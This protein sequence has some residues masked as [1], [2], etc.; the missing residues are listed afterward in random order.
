MPSPKQAVDRSADRPESDSRVSRRMFLRAGGAGAL[1][2]VVAGTVLF[3]EST[4]YAQQKWDH[5]AD[6]VVAGSGGG[7]CTA[8]VFA[9][10]AKAS[11]ILLEKGV[12]FGGT[13]AKS[14]GIFWI[15]NH[16]LLK[17]RG[18]VDTKEDFLR[19]AARTGYPTVYNPA[20]NARLGIPDDMYQLLSTFYDHGASTIDALVALGLKCHIWP[21]LSGNG[22]DMPDYYAQLPE[23]KVPRGRG[24][25]PDKVDGIASGASLIKQLRAMIDQRKIPVLMEH[26]VARLVLNGKGEVVGVEAA[27]EGKIVTIRAHKGVIFG[28]GGFTANAEMCFNYLRG[29]IFGGCGVQTNE[30]DLVKIASAVRAKL[31]NMNH[32]WWSSVLV[33]QALQ[34]RATPGNTSLPG[35]S[36]VSV[37]CYGKRVVNE[38]LQYNERTQA[39]FY[40]DPVTGRYPNQILM[41]IYDQSSRER[42][43]GTSGAVVRP[44]LN[45]PYVISGNTLE[46]LT[47]AIDARLAKI[48]DK[49]GNYRLDLSFLPNL[50]ETIARFNQF[51]E[52]G[53]D[54]DFHR[55]EAPVEFA[56]HGQ[57]R[58]NT[59][60]NITMKP[61]ANTGPYYAVLMGGGT[62]DTKG[63]PKIS[64]KGEI[65]DVDEKPIPGLY[66]CGN[67]IASPA[68]QAYWAG[69]GT[70]GPGMVFGALAAKAAASST[71]KQPEASRPVARSA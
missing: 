13:T 50:K 31:G 29:P 22:K 12:S 65:L 5:E 9:A 21:D 48:A 58:G 39:H 20:D 30:G 3:E 34:N 10:E 36:S 24:L 6:I 42:F 26:R 28:T 63:G 4:A 8:A 56:F 37:N 25:E 45:A 15:P 70:I 23:D 61:I 68:G 19:Y 71:V 1:T 46:E 33:E 27:T 38:K 41:N 62:L 2:G 64:T 14:G 32:A 44:G 55:G 18:I 67:C 43:G 52:T 7:A 51:A 69:G 16:H 17:Q 54:L 47:A 66:G 60:P 57:A 35:D 11:V 59:Y 49:T 53:K 40:W